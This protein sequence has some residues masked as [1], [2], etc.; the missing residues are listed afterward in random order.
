MV[1]MAAR[2][3]FGEG[4][5]SR[6]AAFVYTL[7][8]V[9]VLL[10]VTSLPG[11][12]PMLLLDRDASNVP[13]AAL[14]A[15]PFGPALSAAVFALRQRRLDLTDL[16]PAAAFWRGYRLN[17][18]G[19]LRVW[20]PALVWLAIV[21]VTLGNFAAAGVP[22]WWAVALVVIAVAVLLC[23]AN[24]LVITSLF[25]FRTVDVAR[26]SAY[27]LLRSG[28]TTLGNAALVVMSAAVIYFTSEAVLAL[29]G[30]VLALALLRNSQPM[31]SEIREKFV[32]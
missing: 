19:A 15:V 13:L 3:Q 23:A 5:L 31:I 11:I 24:A 32:A 28:R 29:L 10:V 16:K 17:L 18:G 27:F 20:L 2:E 30:S 9:E 7:L 1:D 25:V 6:A 8:V 26:L 21:G 12:V 14:C 22:T 4:P